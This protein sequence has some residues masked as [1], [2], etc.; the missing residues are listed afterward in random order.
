[1]AERCLTHLCDA[2]GRGQATARDDEQA[3]PET[4]CVDGV[5]VQ[6]WYGFFA[7]AK[8]PKAVID[9]LNRALNQVL[10][11]PEIVKR[12]E[13]HGADVETSTPEAFGALVKTELDK[14]KSV[15]QRARLTAD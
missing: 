6:Q 8:T 9:K 14:W 5:E 11:D 7:P 12:L 2:L 15:V 13:D 4:E 1:M 10:A 3:V